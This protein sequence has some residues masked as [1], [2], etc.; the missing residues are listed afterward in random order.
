[1][2][3]GKANEVKNGNENLGVIEL[4][5][6]DQWPIGLPKFGGHNVSLFAGQECPKISD[7]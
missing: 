2:N 6:H 5:E 1:M 4:V 3:S 7:F